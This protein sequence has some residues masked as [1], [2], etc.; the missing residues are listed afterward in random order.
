MDSERPLQVK[1]ALSTKLNKSNLYSSAGFVVNF[2][3][4]RDGYSECMFEAFSGI[5]EADS[6]I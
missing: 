1:R 2:C 4:L 6:F 3:H 5:G